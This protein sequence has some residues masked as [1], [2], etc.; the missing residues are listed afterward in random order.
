[1]SGSYVVSFVGVFHLNGHSSHV[2]ASPVDRGIGVSQWTHNIDTG[3][4]EMVINGFR[5][6]L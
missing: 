2:D 4:A 5:I 6:Y 3:V 1:M